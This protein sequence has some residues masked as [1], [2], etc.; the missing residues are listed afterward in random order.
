METLL[1]MLGDTEMWDGSNANR[2]QINLQEVVES[3]LETLEPLSECESK[4][5]VQ[6]VNDGGHKFLVAWLVKKYPE[7][8]FDLRRNCTREW[9]MRRYSVPDEPHL[10]LKREEDG[11]V[12]VDLW[13]ARR[14]DKRLPQT[15]KE[16]QKARDTFF[17]GSYGY[18]RNHLDDLQEYVREAEYGEEDLGIWVKRGRFRFKPLL[19]FDDQSVKKLRQDEARADVVV[20]LVNSSTAIPRGEKFD[21]AEMSDDKWKKILYY[22]TEEWGTYGRVAL[23][24]RLDNNCTTEGKFPLEAGF[25]GTLSVDLFRTAGLLAPGEAGNRGIGTESVVLWD[26]AGSVV[27]ESDWFPLEL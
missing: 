1:F 6:I 18:M 17:W 11:F 23:E 20:R 24:L 19:W 5:L 22:R 14:A 3:P 26:P 25:G 16:F 12:V 2:W 27:E 7:A 4:R 21:M 10:N 13:H 8:K 9:W 15:F